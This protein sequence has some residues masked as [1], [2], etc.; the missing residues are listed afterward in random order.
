MGTP[1]RAGAG[2]AKASLS[3][4][5]S[6]HLGGKLGPALPRAVSQTLRLEADS[7]F[8][9]FGGHT[10]TELW[11]VPALPSTASFHKHAGRK[12]GDKRKP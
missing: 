9:A 7:T 4:V 1:M 5:V 11:F 8:C 2:A 3:A 12:T 6:L 10:G